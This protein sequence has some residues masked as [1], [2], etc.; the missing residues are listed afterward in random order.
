MVVVE[1]SGWEKISEEKQKG[2]GHDTS[3]KRGVELERKKKK[4][5][6]K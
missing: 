6:K 1:E 5:N 3:K 4:T 2:E